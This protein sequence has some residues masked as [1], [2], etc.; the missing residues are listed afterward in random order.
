M[1]FKNG[2]IHVNILWVTP[3]L[4]FPPNTGGKTV[5][6]NRIKYLSKYHDI[7]LFSFIDSDEDKKY[8]TEALKYCKE[9]HLYNRNKTI[10]S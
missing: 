7:Y 2:G 8:V 3:E 4:S 1:P 5:T 10:K 6:Y 9:V